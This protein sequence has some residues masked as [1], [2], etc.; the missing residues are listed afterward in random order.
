MAS[1]IVI[2]NIRYRYHNYI[3]C[4]LNKL[5]SYKSICMP[6][7]SFLH[8]SALKQLSTFDDSLWYVV[9]S[10]Y[11]LHWYIDYLVLAQRGH[12]V[13]C[14]DCV[15]VWQLCCIV[16]AFTQNDGCYRSWPFIF[17]RNSHVVPVVSDYELCLSSLKTTF[18]PV[19][20]RQVKGRITYN[21]AS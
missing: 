16:K 10:L 19:P 3:V 20:L 12:F 9:S 15:S 21:F 5:L 6:D 18:H 11:W 17:W 13:S 8:M 7:L 2:V 4:T 1:V 14:K